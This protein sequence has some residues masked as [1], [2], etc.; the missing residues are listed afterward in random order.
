MFNGTKQTVSVNSMT[1][2]SKIYVNG[3]FM[4]NDAVSVKLPRKDG[5]SIVVKKEGCETQILSV[6]NHVQAGWIVFDA[7]FNWFAFLTDAPTGAWNAF[8]RTNYTVELN[9]KE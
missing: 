4:G 1:P 7:L 2:N 5:H 3:E 9:C 8:D 6:T